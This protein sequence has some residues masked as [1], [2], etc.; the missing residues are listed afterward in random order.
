MIWILFN[1]VSED[2]MLPQLKDGICFLLDLNHLDKLEQLG[3]EP[4]LKQCGTPFSFQ[5][6]VQMIKWGFDDPPPH[7]IEIDLTV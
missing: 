3:W 2:V 5:H 1:L 6:S 4:L 7:T